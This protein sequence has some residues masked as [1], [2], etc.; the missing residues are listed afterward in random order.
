MPLNS[1]YEVSERPALDSD[2]LNEIHFVRLV[3]SDLTI[4]VLNTEIRVDP[5]L[6][7]TYVEAQLL[8]NDHILLIKR[9]GKIIQTVEFIMPVV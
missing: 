4:N 1:D 3:R 9:D 6:M 8:V 5:V 2:N 7:Y